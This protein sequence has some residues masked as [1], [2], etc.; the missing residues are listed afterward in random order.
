MNGQVGVDGSARAPIKVDATKG[1]INLPPS[2]RVADLELS[3]LKAEWRSHVAQSLTKRKAP[4]TQKA[5]V[6]SQ[7]T[8]RST[9]TSNKEP[10]QAPNTVNIAKTYEPT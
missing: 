5:S 2:K 1:S 8:T 10:G 7:S 9:K 6:V 3:R 4:M